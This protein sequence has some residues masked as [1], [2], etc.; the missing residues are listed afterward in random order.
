MAIAVQRQTHPFRY[1]GLPS[2]LWLSWI[3]IRALLEARR[4][5]P[6]SGLFRRGQT[7]KRRRPRISRKSLCWRNLDRKDRLSVVLAVGGA[8][9]ALVAKLLPTTYVVKVIAW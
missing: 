7:M 9:V 5:Q 2:N 4:D 6:V 8:L 3:R 1:V